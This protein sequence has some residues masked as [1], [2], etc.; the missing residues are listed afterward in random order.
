MEQKG[1][2][3]FGLILVSVIWGIN[4]AVS[5]VA[6]ETFDPALFAFLRFGL[7]VP[8]FFIVLKAKEGSVL[9]D[10]R[11]MAKMALLGLFGVAGLEIVVMYSIK[12]TTLANASLLNVAPWPIFAALFTPLFTREK[13]TSRLIA[14][15]LASMVGVSLVILGGSGGFDLSAEHMTGNL[16]A[17]AASITGALYNL[18]SI[19]LMRK[20]SALKVSTWTIAFGSLFML[21][22]TFGTWSEVAWRSLTAGHHAAIVYN[23]A[24]A[25][26]VAFVAWNACMYR[27]GGTRANFFRYVVPVTAAAAGY[28]AFGESITWVQIGGA[29]LIAAALAWISL[30]KQDAGGE[31]A[32]PAA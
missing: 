20:Y 12:F 6:M 5:R 30:E 19:P 17:L 26:V 16:L 10:P 22:L 23:V 15:G 11:S 27:V 24:V 3:H 29:L 28:F 31:R 1:V 8:L 2:H 21:P 25:T 9:A 14:G 4:F 13:I 7:S 32:E 18:A